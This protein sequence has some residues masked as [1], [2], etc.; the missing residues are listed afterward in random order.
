MKP[1]HTPPGRQAGAIESASAVGLRYVSDAQAG[2]KRLKAGKA[3]RY[4]DAS[5]KAVRN[6]TLLKRIRSLVIPPAWRDV[7]ICPLD[8][9]HLQ[10]TGR[11]ARGRKQSRYHPLWRE[12]RDATK[13]DHMIQFAG[14]MPKVRQRVLRDMARPGLSRE[15]V[16]ATIVRLMDL[17]FIR[18]GNE[19]YAKENGSFGLTTLQDKHARVE[20]ERIHFTFRGKS[21]KTHAIQ[22]EDRHLA[23]IVQHCQDIPGQDLFQFLDANGQR[24]DVTSGDVNDYL[25]QIA[26]ADF[27]AKDFR[28]WAGTVL[29]AQALKTTAEF[30]TQAQAKRNIKQAIDIVAQKLGNTPAVCRKCYIHP[31]VLDGY[32]KGRMA[33]RGKV[34]ESAGASRAIK[35]SSRPKTSLGCDEREVLQFLRLF[36]EQEKR[37]HRK[38]KTQ[39]AAVPRAWRPRVLDGLKVGRR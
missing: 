31:F 11:D 2:I 13:Y 30:K 17:T 4:I 10:A 6:V 5:G 15:K 18:V 20:K 28:T 25:R 16:L 23:R 37:E 34:M 3:F 22:I 32:M 33:C 27:T 38:N 35:T 21:G 29:T 19:E 26:G 1:R 12:V 8:N 36:R 14:V 9:G 39:L 24:R 7:W